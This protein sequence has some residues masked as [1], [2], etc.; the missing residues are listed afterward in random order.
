[1][2]VPTSR[3]SPRV[4]ANPDSGTDRPMSVMALLKRSRSSAVAMASALAP[5][6]STLKRS[7]IPPSWRA[8]ARFKAV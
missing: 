5:I 1:M 4:Y 2:L 8:L 7:R 6:I 3:A